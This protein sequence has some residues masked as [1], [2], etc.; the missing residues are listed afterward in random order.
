MKRIFPAGAIL[1]FAFSGTLATA[2]KDDET[3]EPRDTGTS[4]LVPVP[5]ALPEENYAPS[6]DGKPYRPI[7]VRYAASGSNPNWDDPS[8]EAKTRILSRMTGFTAD[9][10]RENYR[11]STNRYGSRTDMAPR[12]ATGRFR[13]EKVDGRWWIVDPDGYLNLH[14]G[15][16]TFIPGEVDRD[17]AALAAKYGT[18]ANWIL[19]AAREIAAL[20]F[21]AT[22]AFSKPYTHI[23]GYNASNDYLPLTYAP[24][25]GF[26]SGAR[27]KGGYSWPGDDSKNAIGLV[28]YDGFEASVRDY[29]REQ[30]APYAGDRNLLGVFSDNEI[31]FSSMNTRI[32]AELLAVGDGENP[33]RK[34]AA[35]FMVSKGLEPTAGAFEASGDRER[36]NDEFAGMMA[37]RYYKACRDAIK[38]VD[39]QM[40]YLGSR[41]HGTPKY[42]ENVVRAAGRYC[43]IVSIN[44]YNRWSVE[45]TDYVQ[46][47]ADWADAPFMV[48]EFYAMGADSGL[49]NT[50]GAGFVV[51]TQPERAFFYQHFCLG[52][53]E[54]RNCVGWDWFRYQDDAECNR[55]AFD[56]AYK[57]WPELTSYMRDL[58]YNV[59]RLIDYFD[60]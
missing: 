50:S 38:A 17:G 12:K 52:L 46:R 16:N 34:A 15:L 57:P 2:C 27:S 28:F 54:A 7:L 55:G 5:E 26:L 18:E 9:L 49:P 10:D 24:S 45:L 48:T 36:L 47:W 44:Y 23:R 40:M 53:L 19:M 14:R 22:G 3:Q 41:L 51:R 42:M 20:G 58:N 4:Y 37:E 43:D 35:A 13:T 8:K 11:A 1:L 60:R 25:F 33:A 30:L 39:P 21:H 59:Y 31:N 29:A 6:S 56:A 32:L